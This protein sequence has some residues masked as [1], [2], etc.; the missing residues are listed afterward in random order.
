MAI[1]SSVFFVG[2]LLVP[3][4]FLVFICH[5]NLA[6][7]A[8]INQTNG[9]RRSNGLLQGNLILSNGNINTMNVGGEVVSVIGIKDGVIIYVGENQAD[10][11]E[12]FDEPPSII[13]LQGHVA[14]PG[15]IDCHN[16]IV[17]LGN[18]PGY[19]TP[20]ENAYSIADVQNTYR[21][22]AGDVPSGS[23]ITTIGGFHPNQFS[24]RR[25]PTLDE[26]DQA[27]PDSPVF[28]SFGFT[29]PATTNSLGKAYFESLADPPLIGVNGSISS[30]QNN[31]KAL[32]ALRNQLTFDDR[33]RGVRDAMEY[34]V[35]LG[36]TTHI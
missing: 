24:E 26:L 7:G 30:G 32:L 28:I 31:G 9:Y 8:N 6:I 10:A 13:D 16:H 22:R 35:S 4:L 5:E 27:I 36:V 20:L 19:H 15:L 25:L 14:I 21:S 34:A 1:L 18:R 23:F 17:L 33:K 12:Q 11:L 3:L 29:G 2:R